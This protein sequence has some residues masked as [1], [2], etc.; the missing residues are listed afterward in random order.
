M[1][2]KG[3]TLI[4]LLVVIAI[5]AILAAILFPVFAQAREK[6]RSASCQSNLKQLGIAHAM[7]AQDYDE[8]L[9]GRVMWAPRLEPYTKNWQIFSCPNWGSPVVLTVK[10]YCQT[11]YGQYPMLWGIKGGYCVACY[12]IGSSTGYPLAN[13]RY[14]AATIWLVEYSASRSPT[15]ASGCTQH[16]S[17]YASCAN[18]PWI[19]PRHTDGANFP[20]LDGH[21]KWARWNDPPWQDPKMIIWLDPNRG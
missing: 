9:T 2:R 4:E 11:T 18:G 5:I 8:M 6:A 19:T 14:P 15:S 10:A 3:F 7:Y 20:F 1:K 12:S 21:V 13:I 17:P 16:S